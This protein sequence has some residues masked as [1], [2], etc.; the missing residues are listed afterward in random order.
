MTDIEKYA[1]VDVERLAKTIHKPQRE[2]ATQILSMLI[3]CDLPALPMLMRWDDLPELSKE[4]YRTQ[5]RY[6]INLYHVIPKLDGEK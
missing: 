3:E 6:L 1:H 2:Y 4:G 5:A